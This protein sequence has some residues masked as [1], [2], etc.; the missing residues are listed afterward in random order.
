MILSICLT[1]VTLFI[2]FRRKNNIT[3]KHRI[4]ALEII[5]KKAEKI[6]E[7]DPEDESWRELFDKL[8]AYGTYES[9]LFDP[10]KWTFKQ[11]YPG[12]EDL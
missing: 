3:F 8:K 4:R 7:V 5:T 9:M 6:A 10:L 1:I 12:I 2:I 11:H